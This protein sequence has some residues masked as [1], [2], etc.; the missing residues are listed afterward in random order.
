MDDAAAK[1]L[2]A[3]EQARLSHLRARL[4]RDT[5]DSVATASGEMGADMGTDTFERERAVSML[6][7]VEVELDEVRLAFERLAVGRYGLCESCGQPIDPNRLEAVPATRYCL[8]HEE[9]FELRAGR[10][11]AFPLPEGG[12]V[13]EDV[14]AEFLSEDDPFAVDVQESN[15]EDAL[16][17]LA[18]PGRAPEPHDE[19]A[20]PAR[21]RDPQA[22]DTLIDA[23]FG[24]AE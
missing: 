20:R 17:L 21:D 13:P 6:S 10:A 19:A 2:L 15:E 5:E 18:Q 7:D 11:A 23:Q 14:S 1:H 12:Q 9:R 4:V 8:S 16:H 24:T 3:T 22:V